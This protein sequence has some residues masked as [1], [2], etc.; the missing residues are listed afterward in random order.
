MSTS[1]VS[2]LTFLAGCFRPFLI[3]AEVPSS[4]LILALRGVVLVEAST[5]EV[6]VTVVAD[7][8][9]PCLR[10]RAIEG[11]RASSIS[12]DWLETREDSEEAPSLS[13]SRLTL[14]PTASG[15]VKALTEAA[16]DRVRRLV[17]TSR[18]LPI[19]AVSRA[20]RE[21]FIRSCHCRSVVPNATFND[22]L[23]TPFRG[24]F[25][26]TRLRRQSFPRLSNPLVLW[27]EK[28]HTNSRDPLVK[29][30]VMPTDDYNSAAAGG[31]RLKGV[32]P[33]S[34]VSKHKK[35]RPKPSAEAKQESP[36]QNPEARSPMKE[37]EEALD[38]QVKGQAD[39][40]TMEEERVAAQTR[41]KTLAEIQH[42]ERRR[43]RVCSLPTRVARV[44]YIL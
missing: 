6:A 17:W 28:S 2:F 36:S 35:K 23:F 14:E 19:L 18:F 39:S 29:S 26:A 24:T 11:A 33:S 1:P 13:P 21:V 7:A 12:D 4:V 41:G 38:A 9:F 40:E 20:T 30:A 10:F 25:L 32:N 15:A 34:K 16:N 8:A 43:R 3:R 27:L 44:S 42:E 22:T 5:V 37:D 31:L